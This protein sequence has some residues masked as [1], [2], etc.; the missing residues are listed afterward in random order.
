MNPCAL[1]KKKTS[2]YFIFE[3]SLIHC[4]F[5]LWVVQTGPCHVYSHNI[6]HLE[7]F[8]SSDLRTLYTQAEL[9]RWRSCGL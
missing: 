6:G 7:C 8:L 2:A 3:S 9:P 4:V 5:N 1:I